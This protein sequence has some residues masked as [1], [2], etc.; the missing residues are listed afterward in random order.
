MPRIPHAVRKSGQQTLGRAVVAALDTVPKLTRHLPHARRRREGLS[1]WEDVAYRATGDQ[2][3]RLDVFQ[4]EGAP[5]GQPALV[6]VHGGGFSACSKATHISLAVTFARRGFTVFNIDYRLAPKHRYPAAFEDL[7]AALVFIRQ[8]A[9]DYGAD[10]D[11]VTLAGE[12]AGANLITAAALA[13]SYDIDMAC[14]EQLSQDGP[15]IRA[16]LAGCGVYQVSDMARFWRDQGRPPA[17]SARVARGVA[18]AMEEAYLGSHAEL[19][20]SQV[21]ADPVVLLERQAPTR[22]LPPFFVFC[23]TGDF[24]LDD[25]HRLKAALDLRG[26]KSELRTYAGEPHAFHALQSRPA[27]VA[28]WRD[29]DD[30]IAAH[31]GQ[32]LP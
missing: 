13:R 21:L 31:L 1:I 30:F 9:A 4:V 17:P 24:L 5:A 14:A 11:H 6:Y 2:A 26:A 7:V 27:A 3:H 32:V 8:R 10:G 28:C 15:N 29:H 19:P 20:G 16:V 12:S 22:A 18:R 25:S 23:G